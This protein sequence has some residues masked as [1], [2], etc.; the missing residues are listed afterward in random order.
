ME[1]LQENEAMSSEKVVFLTG[2]SRGIGR[3]AALLLSR[4]HPVALLA[5]DKA[6]L[7]DL[8]K[9]IKAHGGRCLILPCDVTAEFNVAQAVDRVLKEFGRIDVLINN[10]GIGMFQRADKFS[11]ADFE[12]LFKVNVYGMFYCTKYVVPSMIEKK[13]GLIVNISSVA[14]LGGFK[15]GSAYSATKFAV[16]G[17]TESLREDVKEFGIAV[18]VV[19]PGGVN[20][21]FGGGSST[22][23]P[24]RDFLLEPEDVAKTLE[25]L[26]NESET[27][28]TK[29]IELKPR[30]RPEFR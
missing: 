16:N 24:G 13:K 27:A 11:S 21:G 20:T 7:E 30:R 9:E 4:H 8:E 10:A 5:R 19:C 6:A 26:V 17:F 29:M 1:A 23:R 14:G 28:N 15:S 12:T 18:S 22:S 3:A 25:Y 2:A